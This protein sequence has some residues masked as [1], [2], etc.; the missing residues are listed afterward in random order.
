[1]TTRRAGMAGVG[2]VLAL[3]AL[4]GCGAPPPEVAVAE[5]TM[6]PFQ[7]AIASNGKVE[8]VTPHVLRAQLDTFVE[9]VHVLEGR[10]VRRGQVLVELDAA[11]PRS[12]LARAQGELLTAQETLRLARA[13]GRPEEMAKL[14]SDLKKTDAE[15]ARLRSEREALQRLVERQA[16]TREELD[17]NKLA[18]DQAEAEWGLLQKRKDDL[19]RRAKVDIDQATLQI[20]QARNS[21]RSLE[22][23]I[24][25]SRVTAPVDGTLYALPA[26]AGDFV[27]VGDLVA[28]LADLQNVRV[29]AFVDEPDLG[30][31]REAQPVDITWDA[32][33][34]RTWSGT[35]EVA[36]KAVVARGTRSV[37]E[38][39][40]SVKNER[41]ELLPNVNVNVR[42]RV[43]EIPSA[44][45]VP[46]GAVR[47][48]AAERYVFVVEGNT[49]RKRIIQTGMAGATLYEV[50]GGLQAGDR[51]ALP[52]AVELRDGM[53]IRPAAPR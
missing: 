30:G 34:G 1:M 29:R 37:G 25:S 27:R 15:L 41:I 48:D 42:I 6:A 20:E 11:A 7:V 52:G 2:A 24:R 35:V 22:E 12:E 10:S 13:G 16:A 32:M 21:I 33:P 46:R 38:V 53:T 14:E 39:L 4:T 40:C 26:R 31:L 23:K 5:A 9:K 47:S 3:M 45:V 49:L 43:R 51:V 19:A 17:R 50:T 18:L 44:L 28:E 36:P 8:P